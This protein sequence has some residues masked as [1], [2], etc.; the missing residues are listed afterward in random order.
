M[1]QIIQRLLTFDKIPEGW[2]WFSWMSFLRY[3]WG[4]QMLNQYGNSTVGQYGAYWDEETEEVLTVLN[5]YGLEGSVM[6]STG[7]CVA[8]LACCTLFFATC[9][10]VVLGT[11]RHSSR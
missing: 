1:R 10:A 4:A 3:S 2:Y 9:G 8:L 11:V 7:V 6:G 5:F